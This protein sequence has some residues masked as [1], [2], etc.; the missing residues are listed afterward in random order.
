MDSRSAIQVKND[1]AAVR[2]YQKA[3]KDGNI[4][5]ARRIVDANPDLFS[6]TK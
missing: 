5:K 3:V 2:E 4:A 1:L 6:W